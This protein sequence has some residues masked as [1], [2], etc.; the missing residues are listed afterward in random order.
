LLV[1]VAGAAADPSKPL[2]KANKALAAGDYD[3]AHQEFLRHAT[4]KGNALAQFNLALMHENGW[5]RPA[6][7]VAACDWHEKAASGGIPYSSHR[8]AECL[9]NGIGRPADAKAAADWYRK[10]AD[11]G[12]FISLCDL[13]DLYMRGKG[14]EKDPG[15]A[16]ALCTKAAERRL[17]QAQLRVARY[18]LEGDASIRDEAQGI[19]W[20]EAAAAQGLPEA[21][22]RLGMLLRAHT[23]HDGSAAVKA[24]YLLETAASHGYLPA[25]LP[26]GELYLQ[27]PR[28]PDSGRLPPDDLA[29][30]YLWLSAAVRRLEDPASL[31]SA[32][33]LLEKVREAMPQ[34]WAP[35]LDAKVNAHLAEHAP[36][37]IT[38]K[39]DSSPEIPEK[40]ETNR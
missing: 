40:G 28:D 9:I 31:A 20:L 25:Y 14:V 35:S 17:P 39:P 3:R 8:L 6:D 33:A 16:A 29:K 26:V 32:K 13:G 12:H 23:G 4:D 11:L 1:S 38:T 5:G 22:Y 2:R 21:Q 24:R 19:K 27:A 7:P 37:T 30:A 36:E 15:E 18:Y 10:A 34:T